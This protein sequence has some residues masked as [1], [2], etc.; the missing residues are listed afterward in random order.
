LKGTEQ[1]RKDELK[2]LILE[3]IYLYKE[4]L[5]LSNY[6]FKDIFQALKKIKMI[7]ENFP[8]KQLSKG[9]PVEIFKYMS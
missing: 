8:F 9:L 4:Y 6:N 1:E 2:K 5:Q 7:K 3:I